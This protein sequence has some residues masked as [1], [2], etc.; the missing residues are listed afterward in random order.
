MILSKRVIEAANLSLAW[1][2]AAS[3]LLDFGPPYR[4]VNLSIRIADPCAED[5]EL[6]CF[7]ED[8]AS[9]L[10]LQGPDE[11]ANT[12]YPAEW[13]RDL[14][15]PKELSADYRSHYPVLKA[16]G[17]PHGTYF[18]RLVAFPTGPHQTIDQLTEIIEK[19]RGG[20]SGGR[21]YKSAYE[22]NIYD[23]ARDARKTRG[24][25]CLA[26][27]GLH[28]DDEMRLNASALY[29]SHDVLAK[30]YGNYLGLSGLLAYI[31]A[32]ADL[33]CGEL[34]VTAGGAFL[35]SARV[36]R[37]ATRHEELEAHR[38]SAAVRAG[39]GSSAA[40]KT[41]AAGGPPL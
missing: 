28:L 26:H 2:D 23:V 16:L 9:S 39:E 15:D 27:L 4:A 37:L 1:A 34:M 36:R 25:P 7:V 30:G 22:L 17:S 32:A 13:A 12:I 35:D 11:V 24:F 8:L 6:R 18:G 21:R 5:A 31:A 38:A 41:A 14:P 40:D 20:R 10:G 33:E 19:L 3:A 29:R